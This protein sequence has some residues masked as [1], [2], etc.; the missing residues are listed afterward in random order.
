MD[1]IDFGEGI[2]Q[3]LQ[4][5]HTG[6]GDELPPHFSLEKKCCCRQRL[7][8]MTT[9]YRRL[10]GESCLKFLFDFLEDIISLSM[11]WR[12]S[13]SQGTHISDSPSF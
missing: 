11:C 6:H 3:I 4:C 12:T 10:K 1:Y 7:A 8:A 13:E 9:H 5:V 2:N